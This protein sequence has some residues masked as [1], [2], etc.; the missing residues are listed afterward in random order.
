MRLGLFLAPFLIA[1]PAAAKVVSASPNAFHVRHQATLVVPAEE[2]YAL[3]G[4]PSQWWN[5]EHSYSLDAA[6]FYMT[7][8]PGG[9]FC[10]T[11]P[12]GG[13]VE[14]MRV[15]G[16]EPGKSILLSGPLGPLRTV[17]ASGIMSWSLEP[18]AGGSKLVFDFKVTGFP[19][20]DGATWAGAVDGVIGEQVKRFRSRVVSKG[21]R[22]VP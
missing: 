3:L 12:D 7:L 9:C 2:A 20:G 10:E 5:G 1:S 14:H 16:V 4:Q 19:A 21:R 6:N 11:M 15:I 22:D 18:A 8:K 13:F 17:P